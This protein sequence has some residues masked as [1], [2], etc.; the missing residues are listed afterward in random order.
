M[1]CFPL[2]FPQSMLS[3][4]FELYF[5]L[6]ASLKI[7]S[8]T[9]NFVDLNFLYSLSRVC[10]FCNFSIKPFTCIVLILIVW[11]G[12]MAFITQIEFFEWIS[13]TN[14]CFFYKHIKIQGLGSVMLKAT[15]LRILAENMLMI[16]L[17]CVK[18]HEVKSYSMEFK[19]KKQICYIKFQ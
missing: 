18:I 14:V 6:R 19:S 7:P 2:V 9:C 16:C 15:Q 1:P 17:H 3:S 11:K 4:F 13:Q 5:V 12:P 10:F 8:S